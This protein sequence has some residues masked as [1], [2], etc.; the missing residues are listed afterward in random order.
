MIDLAWSGRAGVGG[1]RLR[2]WCD[3]ANVTTSASCVRKPGS[4]TYVEQGRELAVRGG[5]GP[6]DHDHSHRGAD[7]VV[8]DPPGADG[9][10]ILGKSNASKQ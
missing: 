1:V 2:G 4:T 8:V 9:G 10:P 3:R 7:V 5:D 6:H